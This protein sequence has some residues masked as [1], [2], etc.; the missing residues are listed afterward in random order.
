MLVCGRGTIRSGASRICQPAPAAGPPFARRRRHARGGRGARA[1]T[2]IGVGRD[3]LDGFVQ[4]AAALALPDA[5]CVVD[6]GS[7]SGDALASLAAMRPIDGVGIDLSASAAAQRPALPNAHL[8]GG[9]RRSPPSASRP[10]CRSRPV[11]TR[12]TQPGGMRACPRSRWLPPGRRAGARRPDRT[13][14][15]GAGSGGRARARR[16]A[17]GRTRGVLHPGRSRE[18]T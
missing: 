15:V 14:R 6:L 11:A 18:R 12:Q 16:R 8:G 17:R 7:G 9:Q 5:A 13:A 2:G 3:V 4:R 1:V 10:E